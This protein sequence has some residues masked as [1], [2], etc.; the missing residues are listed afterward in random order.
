MTIS[1][2]VAAIIAIP[3]AANAQ[4]VRT[5]NKTENTQ[6][7]TQEKKECLEECNK[8]CKCNKDC[9]Y[10]KCKKS[11]YKYHGKKW[12]S[13]KRKISKIHHGQRQNPLFNGITLSE[14]QQQQF[15]AL[16]EKQRSERKAELAELKKGQNEQTAQKAQQHK[17]KSE[18]FDREVEKILTTDQM[19]QY[20][21]NKE[22]MKAN[23]V[24]MDKNRKERRK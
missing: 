23:K 13:S 2:A 15:Q 10:R 16:R 4:E 1:L 5:T 11:D 18:A 19:K 9:D 22:A 3:S 7:C 14:Q 17:L 8:E 21:A 12:K 20:K 24:S 6:C